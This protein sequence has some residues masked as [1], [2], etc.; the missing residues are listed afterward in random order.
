MLPRLRQ[1]AA[2]T[3]ALERSPAVALLGP[4]QCGKTTLARQLF[5]GRPRATWFDLESPI[6]LARLENPILA[7]GA[8]RDFVVIDEVQRKPELFE[9]LRVLLDAPD[10]KA[11]FL[12]LG[13]ASPTIVRGVS[14]SLAGRVAFVDMG[15][16]DLQETGADAWPD[17]W[18]RG[19]LPRSYLARDEGESAAWREDFVR[20]FLERDLPQL[21]GVMTPVTMRRFW[22]MLAHYHGQ[23]LNTSELSR[24][25]GVTETS[26]RRHL[27]LLAGSYV[28]RLLLPWHE[29]LKKRQVKSPKVYVRD[30]GLLHSLLSIASTDQLQSHPKV[31][32][33][34]EGFALEQILRL[35]NSREAYFWATHAG[36]ELDLL[37]F[38]GA[39]R[40]GFEFKYGDV[41]RTTKS[42]RVAIQD[43]GLDELHIVYPGVQSFDLDVNI[44]A[45]AISDL[46]APNST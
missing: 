11:V 29:N 40:L 30:S 28:L 10:R 36:A 7:L 2:V 15:G 35:R 27:E 23:I 25:L 39:R 1:V 32:A 21:G 34:F 33:S 45:L 20:T 14:E 5:A 18:H 9:V 42:M 3:S 24:A 26:I 44:R 41:P 17:L 37:V 46:V 38:E 12:L 16:F 22:A 19:G 43:L 4:R 8:A 13:S 31:G 6:D